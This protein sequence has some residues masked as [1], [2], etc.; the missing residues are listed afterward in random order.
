[1]KA[2]SSS[3]AMAASTSS[4]HAS[5]VGEFAEVRAGYGFP[6]TLQG[7]ASGDYPFY[8]VSDMNL[9]GNESAMSA[10]NNYVTTSDLPL[11]KA[12]PFDSGTVVFPKVGAAIATNKKRLT[13]CP[14]LVDN[15]VMGVKPDPNVCLPEYLHYWMQ[16]FDLSSIAAEGPLPSITAAAVKAIV[17]SLPP[18]E[19]QWRIIRILSTIERARQSRRKSVLA[20]LALLSS[21]RE[22]KFARMGNLTPLGEVVDSVKYGTSVA[23]IDS[24]PGP[25]V[26][27]IKNVG[28]IV[29]DEGGAKRLPTTPSESDGNWMEE[30]DLL[31][32]RT[33]A[34]Q[35]RIGRCAVY[36]G[37]PARAMFASYLLRARVDC[38]VVNPWY[39]AHY[40]ASIRG[41]ESLRGSGAGAADGKFNLNGPSLRAWQ[42][43]LVPLS[44]QAALVERLEGLRRMAEAEGRSLRLAD[45]VCVA[46]LHHL[47]AGTRE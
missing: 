39:L 47:V 44:E 46:A 20:R 32:V 23:C 6:P 30:G 24:G 40:A 8:K 38:S 11:L 3:D 9:P 42:F 33:N 18:L 13:T 41:R 2:V 45:D 10:A 27:G 22:D 34:D 26:L 31:F 12:K 37:L 7:R 14:C 36:S 15:N 43:P 29:I 5:R 16:T 35:R 28:E 17:I 4:S 19:E 25:V 1:M 21:F